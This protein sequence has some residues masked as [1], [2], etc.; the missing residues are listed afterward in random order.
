MSGTTR[1]Y[2]ERLANERTKLLLNN[3]SECPNIGKIFAG[4]KFWIEFPMRT[5]LHHTSR[6][7][8]D[9]SQL[10]PT[11]IVIS[12]QLW[13]ELENTFVGCGNVNSKNFDCQPQF[14]RLVFSVSEVE[15]EVVID[16]GSNALKIWDYLA[17]IGEYD[18]QSRTIV[19][20]SDVV[21]R[22]FQLLGPLKLLKVAEQL[23]AESSVLLK[24][25]SRLD[26]FLMAIAK[27]HNSS[28]YYESDPRHLYEAYSLPMDKPVDEVIKEWKNSLALE[29]FKIRDSLIKELE[30][31]ESLGY[32]SARAT[33]HESSSIENIQQSIQNYC[34]ALEYDYASSVLD[35]ESS[36]DKL[37][38]QSSVELEVCLNSLDE[39]S[40]IVAGVRGKQST[41]IIVL[42]CQ[43]VLDSDKGRLEE[44]LHNLLDNER[45]SKISHGL[46]KIAK[47]SRVRDF[48]HC[49][50]TGSR[51]SAEENLD[52]ARFVEEVTQA[53]EKVLD[54]TEPLTIM[55]KM[56]FE[57]RSKVLNLW[58]DPKSNETWADDKID[59]WIEKNQALNVLPSLCYN[60]GGPPSRKLKALAKAHPNLT[61][62][63][64]NQ[65]EAD[66]AIFSELNPKGISQFLE[67]IFSRSELIDLLVK[68]GL[69]NKAKALCK[70]WKE[71][72]NKFP[73][74]AAEIV[75]ASLDAYLLRFNEDPASLADA[76]IHACS[77]GLES[78]AELFT[79]WALKKGKPAFVDAA[80]ALAATVFTQAKE[81]NLFSLKYNLEPMGLEDA[82]RVLGQ[83]VDN[84]H[85]LELMQENA[86]KIGLQMDNIECIDTVDRMNEMFDELENCRELIGLDCEATAVPGVA[87][88]GVDLVSIGYR[89]CASETWRIFVVDVLTLSKKTE[90]H[91]RTLI[92]LDN[93]LRNNS[94]A[95]YAF[96]SA[97]ISM[98]N[99]AAEHHKIKFGSTSW[100]N[101][102]DVA[103]FY[104]GGL[105]VAAK[106]ALNIQLVKDLSFHRKWHRRPLTPLQKLYCA[107]DVAVPV[108]LGKKIAEDKTELPSNPKFVK[109]FKSERY[110]EE[111]IACEV[112]QWKELAPK[113]LLVLTPDAP[114][115]RVLR[116]FGLEVTVL[117]KTELWSWKDA[118]NSLLI[119]AE[120][121]TAQNCGVPTLAV[122]NCLPLETQ[123]AKILY[124]VKYG[125]SHLETETVL[126]PN[127]GGN[128][129]HLEEDYVSCKN[130]NGLQLPS[131][132]EGWEKRN[133]IVAERF[134]NSDFSDLLKKGSYVSV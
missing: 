37:A 101:H 23:T 42:D 58:M 77:K 115:A 57:Q 3:M 52:P 8:R 79:E 31:H 2:Y 134:R 112:S 59:I 32:R 98:L 124:T 103:R 82:Q 71:P 70:E 5:C 105:I 106:K 76:C 91:K 54:K 62:S 80:R 56:T 100:K 117:D 114:F 64:S 108:L 89:N 40:V 109:G 49:I 68:A 4:Q 97:D 128:D 72:W 86:D 63:I 92:R 41:K 14:Q 81:R 126:C 6:I 113:R 12:C 51:L 88:D 11:A 47:F 73:S 50:P 36:L 21:Q 122:S 99:Q 15:R 87:F 25:D 111:D 120:A 130:C 26:A 65:I 16:P 85:Q 45:V 123:V 33:S 22:A 61:N 48:W 46:H 19:L 116:T 38:E 39:I 107:F 34:C 28:S 84:P 133:L 110:R 132:L 69:R 10:V 7:D 29:G 9:L 17:K 20:K 131:Q 93:L 1:T 127:D 43:S 53:F 118:E 67:S 121:Q 35:I 13:I 102:I 24:C 83:V 94:T 18:I 66:A 78:H 27:K 119:V 60:R 55:S 90:D 104:P 75:R 129:W 96:N 30:S 74:L 44:K 95:G 125:E